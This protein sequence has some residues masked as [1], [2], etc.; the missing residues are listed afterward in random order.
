MAAALMAN[1]IAASIAGFFPN[2]VFVTRYTGMTVNDPQIAV[3]Q[4]K[5]YPRLSD[6]EIPVTE[7]NNIPETATEKS[8]SGGLSFLTPLG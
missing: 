3:D 8:Y 1:N 6:S 7:C 4:S 2:T 5:E